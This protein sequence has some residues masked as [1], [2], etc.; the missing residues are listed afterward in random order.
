MS[1]ELFAPLPNKKYDI[2]YADPPWRFDIAGQI[3]ENWNTID[4]KLASNNI[5]DT[6]TIND[7]KKLQVENIAKKDCLLFLW[8][9]GAHLKEA[10]E[11]GEAWGF[12]YST[13]GFVWHKQW[14]H[15]GNYTMPDT[16]IVLIFKKGKIPQPFT[17]RNIRQFLSEK[18]TKHSA[19][20]IEIRHRIEKMFAKASRIELFARPPELLGAKQEVKGWDLWGNE[21]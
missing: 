12:K 5:Y 20:P 9:T 11:L 3:N 6:L 4:N 13:I 14:A 1:S 2:I 8:T 17:A 18:R 21:V 10:I 7:I 15:F 19:K 16:E